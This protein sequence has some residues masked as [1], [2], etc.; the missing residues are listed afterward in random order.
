MTA[1]RLVRSAARA[2]EAVLYD[3][4]ARLFESQIAKA[5]GRS[6]R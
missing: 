6:R 2:H 5:R 1:N 3:F 4:M